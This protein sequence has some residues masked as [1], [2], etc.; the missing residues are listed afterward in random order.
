MSLIR[1]KLLFVIIISV[2]I[3]LVYGL[4]YPLRTVPDTA[5]YFQVGKQ[6]TSGDYR[7]YTGRR[8]PVYPLFIAAAGFNKKI[9]AGLQ[10]LMGVGIAVL[11]YLIFSGLTESRT[12][13]FILGLSYALNPSQILFEFTLMTEAVSTFLLILTVYLF[14]KILAKNEIP[15][16]KEFFVLGLA[17]SLCVLTR[18][19]FQILPVI[20]FFFAAYHLKITVGAR[21]WKSAVFL[22]PV[23]ISL[24]LWV[25][26]QHRRIGRYAVTVDLGADLTNHT[27][28]FIEYAPERY[29][30]IKKVLIKNRNFKLRTKGET[31]NS[32]AASMPEL[33]ELTGL[34][35]PELCDKLKEMNLETIGKAPVPY[36]KS[37]FKS[38][39]VFF[40]PTWFGR[41]FGIRPAVESGGWRLKIIASTY[42]VFHL[43][44][45][46]IF[47]IFPLF[48]LLAP[49]LA[50]FFKWTTEIS[51]IYVLVLITGISQAF[52]ESGE[53]ARYKTSVEPLIICLALWIILEF[54]FNR[55]AA[56]REN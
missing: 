20:I 41:L 26:F 34:S 4:S 31:Y 13:G 6:L 32:M 39:A 43:C 11:L 14:F 9:V 21:V 12:F 27:V 28:K 23:I 50:G 17:C 47:L 45:M 10:A 36:L 56:P 54:F 48:K 42:A 49:R 55:R 7:E 30:E 25:D 38:F 5:G 22:I 33:L 3:R 8:T 37:V 16:W 44:S 52:V 35:Y 51:F 18:P 15:N 1:N 40:K 24:G 53:N 19:Q 29:D 46:M 2:S